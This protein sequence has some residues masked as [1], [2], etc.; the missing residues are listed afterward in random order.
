MGQLSALRGRI[1]SV[2]KKYWADLDIGAN[3][4]TDGN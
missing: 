2:V 3:V 1:S 4:A